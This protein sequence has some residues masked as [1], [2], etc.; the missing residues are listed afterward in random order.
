[1]RFISVWTIDFVATHN[2][3][4][5]LLFDVLSESLQGKKELTE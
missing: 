1:M 4:P 5:I 3:D 2:L